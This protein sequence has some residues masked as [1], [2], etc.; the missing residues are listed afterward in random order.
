MSL[1]VI[2]KLITRWTKESRGGPAADARNATPGALP[3]PGTAPGTTGILLH[4]ITFFERD[5]FAP[6]PTYSVIEW[7]AVCELIPDL[8]LRLDE[9][10]LRV[11][12]RYSHALGAPE[13]P[14]GGVTHLGPGQWCRVVH[15]GRMSFDRGWSYHD[16][17]VNI[18]NGTVEHR[19]FLESPPLDVDDHR[20]ELR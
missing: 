10:T 19:T 7:D 14:S 1:I 8:E 6:N 12:Y 2:Q 16:T 13:R 15:N 3:I 17:I 5:R 20:A 11:R 4:T 18:A 9:S